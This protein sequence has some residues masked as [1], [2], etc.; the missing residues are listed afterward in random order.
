MAEKI[1]VAIATGAG[2]AHLG[3]YFSALRSIAE[4]ESVALAD[5]SGQSYKSATKTLGDRL[6]K[7][8]KNTAAMLKEFQPTLTLVSMEA[9]TAPPVIEA[10]LEAGTH[11]FAEKPGCVRAKDFERLSR[12]ADGKHLY[13]MLALANRL[14]PEI[15]KARRLL[16]TGAIGK[17]YAI[18]LQLVADQT[19]L[20]RPSY[21]K[22]WFAKKSRAGGGYLTWLGIHWLDLAAYLTGL[23]VQQV[24]GFTTNVGGQPIDI[25]DSVAASLRFENN[26]L[27]TF[28]C[29][30]FLDRGYQSQI[31]IWG[32][33][34]WIQLQQMEKSPL[35]WYTTKGPDKGKTQ[36]FD[37]PK[38]PRGY[39]PFVQACVRAAAGLQKPPISNTESLH[40][41]QS[42]YSIYDAATAGKTVEV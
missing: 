37:G 18:D 32:S 36:T 23:Q 12:I 7:T 13:L 30:Y 31:K 17:V 27:G 24:A 11:V 34:G 9:A 6:T 21:H 8:Y 4:V 38:Q 33:A 26:V 29:G 3:A 15:Q 42:V 35:T 20:T 5:P 19:R 14:N 22:K 1:K 25:E 16:Q 40:A 28:S 2:G 39:T 10:A 41:I